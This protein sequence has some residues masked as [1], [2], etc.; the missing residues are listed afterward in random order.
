[1][2]GCKNNKQAQTQTQT[3]AHTDTHSAAAAL[4][5]DFA[6]KTQGVPNLRVSAETTQVRHSLRFVGKSKQPHT[7]MLQSQLSAVRT[8]NTDTETEK[9]T[10]P[11]PEP[12]TDTHKKKHPK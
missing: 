7:K 9:E 5:S 2:F 11:E 6:H 8:T 3:Q 1:M 4:M 10:E 12:D